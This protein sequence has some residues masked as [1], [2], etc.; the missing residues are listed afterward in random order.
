MGSVTG[1]AVKITAGDGVE[2]INVPEN[3]Y[4]L[5]GANIRYTYEGKTYLT[6]PVES[7]YGDNGS[8]RNGG[9]GRV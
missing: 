4:T 5:P 9:K 1:S 7:E 6:E 8:F 3:G 2:L